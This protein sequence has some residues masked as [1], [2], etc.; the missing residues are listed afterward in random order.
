MG[1][2][3]VGVESVS[4][5]LFQGPAL[6]GQWPVTPR[7]LTL[8]PVYSSQLTGLGAPLT[9]NFPYNNSPWPG[10]EPRT[11]T[12]QYRALT[13]APLAQPVSQ[14]RAK[15]RQHTFLVFAFLLIMSPPLIG[16]GIKR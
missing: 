4:D 2:V 9:R 16:G 6:I 5:L 14:K 8:D 1:S 15:Q 10:F 12:W 3:S 11:S 7:L 13:T